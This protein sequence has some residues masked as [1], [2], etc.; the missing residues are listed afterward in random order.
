VASFLWEKMTKL[1]TFTGEAEL[2]TMILSEPEYRVL[3]GG[4]I[5]RRAEYF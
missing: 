2:G 3:V 1:V 4:K 5:Y